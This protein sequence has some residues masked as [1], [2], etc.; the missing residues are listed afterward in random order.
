MQNYT[1]KH[2]GSHWDNDLFV[3]YQLGNLLFCLSYSLRH[4]VY[5]MV[6]HTVEEVTEWEFDVVEDTPEWF[7]LEKLS[8]WQKHA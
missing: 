8:E 6:C 1:G 5:T 2:L 4:E 3:L 7:N